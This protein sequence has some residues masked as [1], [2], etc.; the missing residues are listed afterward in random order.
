MVNRIRLQL[1]KKHMTESKLAE[2]IG[3]VCS[4]AIISYMVNGKV[5]PTKSM[6]T[7]MCNVL[8]CNPTDLYDINELNLLS[9]D[10]TEQKDDLTLCED[11]R[12]ISVRLSGLADLLSAS[13]AIKPS[14]DIL[15][16]IEVE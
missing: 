13:K 2:S 3:D 1:A 15:T 6:L 12:E 11:L 5:M 4:P 7:A 8:E 10:G 9:D 14:G 16:G